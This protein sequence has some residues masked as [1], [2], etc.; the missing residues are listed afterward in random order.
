M[1]RLVIALSV[2]SLLF[3][4]CGATA[5]ASASVASL[6]DVP[7]APITIEG[8]DEAADVESSM[9]AFA[10]CMREEGVEVADP[11]VDQDG[12]VSPPQPVDPGSVD[13]EAIRA[14]RTA[15]EEHLEGVELGFRDLDVTA[16]E[17][18]LLAFAQCIRDNGYDMPDPDLNAQQGPAGGPFGQIDRTD[19]DFVA[20]QEACDEILAD[21]GRVPGGRSGAGGGG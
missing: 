4:A 20:A 8:V 16:L 11:G 12:N 19:P 1:K 17:D 9:L 5:D 3:A 7:A 18:T 15:C 14:A 2:M 21:V 10:A 6:D 13:R